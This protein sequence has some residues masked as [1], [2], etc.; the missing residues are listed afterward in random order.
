MSLQSADHDD[1]SPSQTE[2]ASWG[3]QGATHHTEVTKSEIII[4]IFIHGFKGNG[5]TFGFIFSS[6][7][8][9]SGLL[10]SL[11]AV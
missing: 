10:K 11:Y 5:S 6:Q 2:S 9:L 7:F 4:I 3:E 8:N 1:V